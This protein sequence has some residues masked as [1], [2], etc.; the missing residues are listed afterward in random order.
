MDI[1][2]SWMLGGIVVVIVFLVCILS[3]IHKYIAIR[4]QFGKNPERSPESLRTVAYRTTVCNIRLLKSESNWVA[5]L[6]T[7]L[8]LFA[9][10]FTLGRAYV[11]RP[12]FELERSI[13]D[14]NLTAL[15]DEFIGADSDGQEITNLSWRGEK[16]YEQHSF[17]V[18]SSPIP[19]SLGKILFVTDEN[20]I[21]E[22][23]S[24]KLVRAWGEA[25]PANFEE[26]DTIAFTEREFEVRGKYVRP[27]GNQF[28]EGTDAS[29]EVVTITFFD[30]KTRRLMGKVKIE[31]PPNPSQTKTNTTQS[32]RDSTV[33]SIL[34]MIGSEG[35]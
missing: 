31:A 21:N 11:L 15:R 2:L 24:K 29:V 13:E 26:V 1:P 9:P 8:A 4:E 18:T 6:L 28:S 14:V 20:N 12:Y 33:V 7:I 23:L 35:E 16:P 22:N 19:S 5:I 32:V 34:K 27:G 3:P 25:A 17:N 10:L 30:H